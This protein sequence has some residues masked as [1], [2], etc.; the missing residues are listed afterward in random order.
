[1]EKLAEASGDRSATRRDEPYRRAIT[2]IYARLTA[3]YRQLVGKAPPRPA[4]T[5]AEPYPDPQAFR[6]DLVEIA[7]ALAKNGGGLLSSGG[8]LGRLIRSVETF[9]FHLATLD[10]RQNADVHERVVADLL[11]VAGVE[12]DYLALDEDARVALLR[13]ELAN[14]RPLSSP[15]AD[16]A[17]ET[18]SELEIVR[19]A[20]E[21]HRLYGPES[22]TTYLISKAES[23]S[24]L[25]EVNILLKEAGL[26]LP[27]DPRQAAIMAVP[28]FETIGDL[29]N[30]PGVM[31]AWFALPEV[32]AVTTA[33]GHQE[34][35]VGYSDSNK[36]GGYLTSVWSL[37][38]A[39]SALAPV[40]EEAGAA[41]QLFHGR[42][43]AVGRGGGSSFAAIRAQPPGT[44]QGR[45]RIT[46][47]GEVIAAKY[48]TR[49]SA[50]PISR[51]WPRRHCLPA[52]KAGRSARRIMPVFRARWTSFRASRSK[53][54]AISSTAPRA[55]A[56]SSA[57]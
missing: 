1:V 39:S 41:M 51:R 24:D 21:A 20:A 45:I 50:P 38:Q 18:A 46:E 4:S 5:E 13:R 10:M 35:M 34:V 12:P 27:G 30:A 22:I 29:E 43:G 28:L 56:P 57:R 53:A 9:G 23:V 37:H 48:G 14:A 26:Y 55:S 47:Q 52:S 16:Y 31:R 25:L 17:V 54:I 42:G 33:R 44:V 19:A 3:T 11:K 49:E 36:D 6:A 15:F 40:F 7:H 2:G 32:A 8:A